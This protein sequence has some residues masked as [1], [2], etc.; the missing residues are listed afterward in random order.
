MPLTN[1]SMWSPKHGWQG[2]RAD[3]VASSYP[4]WGPY[5]T[6]L[7]ELCDQYVT[8][9]KGEVVVSHFKHGWNSDDCIEKASHSSIVYYR[10]YWHKNPL[11]FS[12]PLRIRIKDDK[13]IEVF[14][15][16][17]PLPQGQL[18]RALPV[19]I[20]AGNS[21]KEIRCFS[22]I[23]RFDPDKISYLSVGNTLANE[24]QISYATSTEESRKHFWPLL[25][26]GF[27]DAGVLFDAKR[28]KRIPNRGYVYVNREYLLFLPSRTCYRSPATDVRVD[29]RGVISGYRLFLVKATNISNNSRD[30]FLKYKARLT[31]QPAKLTLL[32]PFGARSPHVL[33]HTA[34]QIWLHKT[35]GYMN[36]RPETNPRDSDLQAFALAARTASCQ[37]LSLSH[38]ERYAISFRY[39]VLRKVSDIPYI[40]S[41]VSVKI[42]DDNG[43]K[44]E[45][46]NYETLP[47]K[48]T[49]SVRARFDGHI[50]VLKDGFV[51]DRIKLDSDSK[52]TPLDIE[53]NRVYRIYQGGDCACELSFR[54][55]ENT[56]FNDTETL[57]KLKTFKGQ[58]VPVSHTFGA[59]AAKLENMPQTR[60]WLMQQLH[61]GFM[62][63][64]AKNF[65]QQ[66]CAR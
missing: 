45:P 27:S 51:I 41:K 31:D 33:H 63:K 10:E 4:D 59:V 56:S 48:R 11:G 66:L 61:L 18:E 44:I 38:S 43:K 42:F 2:I 49:L 8:F 47:A 19:K 22:D 25:V 3:E 28:G 54:E 60:L 52:R 46:G 39:I 30:F 21:L 15:G 50:D 26:N 16:F 40:P 37:I 12:L 58:S 35:E 65:I 5:P 24:Y 9:V 17:L 53:Y 7:C 6:F 29:D 57:Q 14:I 62:D 23:L 34:E 36:L 20:Y 13:S 64:Q 55:P 32:Y 1:V